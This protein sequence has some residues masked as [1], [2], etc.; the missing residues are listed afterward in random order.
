MNDIEKKYEDKVEEIKENKNRDMIKSI[1]K[2]LIP[3]FI[4]IATALFA[5][6]GIKLGAEVAA[7][8]NQQLW[9]IERHAQTNE[10][11]YDIRIS[12][13]ER[14]NKILYK[15]ELINAIESKANLNFDLSKIKP[16]TLEEARD[17]VKL[18]KDAF[19]EK[20]SLNEYASE[21]GTVMQL[22]AVFF[23]PKTQAAIKELT[24]YEKW[25]AADTKEIHAVIEAMKAEMTYGLS[26]PKIDNGA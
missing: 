3:V 20:I 26:V 8:S 25:W 21:F 6:Y 13:F 1:K 12:L 17:S 10:K 18:L 15:S 7:R 24:K 19:D 9:A 22:S 4:P 14:A 2:I 16:E 23:G 11:F 5:F